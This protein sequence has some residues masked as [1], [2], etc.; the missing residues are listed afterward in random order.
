MEPFTPPP[1]TPPGAPPGGVPAPPDFGALAAEIAGLLVDPQ[2]ATPEEAVDPDAKLPGTGEPALDLSEV[3]QKE[4]ARYL[5]ELLREHDDAYRSRWDREQQIED[6]YAMIPDPKRQGPQPNAAKL[7]SELTKSQVDQA[8]ARIVAGIMGTKPLM[9]VSAND[10]NSLDSAQS[11]EIAEATEIFLQEYGFQDMRLNVKLPL[12][13]LRACKLGTAVSRDMWTTRTERVCYYDAEGNKAEETRESGFLEVVLIHNNDVLLWPPDVEE[14]QEAEVA[15]H[16]ARLSPG[17]FR[18][19]CQEIGVPAEL[20]DSIVSGSWEGSD[21]YQDSRAKR[22]DVTTSGSK[23]LAERIKLTEIWYNGFLPAMD[24]PGKFHFFLHE[25]SQNLL[26]WDYNPLHCQ[27]HPYWPLHYKR[28]DGSAWGEGVGHELVF[29]QAA[30][31]TLDN[32]EIDNLKVVANKILVAKEGTQAE[33]LV[34]EIAP[35]ARIASENPKE[36]LVAVETG[37]SLDNIYAA[38]AQ[39]MQRAVAATGLSSILQGAG[40]PTMKS[41]ADASSVALLAQEGGRKFGDVDRTMRECLDA[42]YL[43]F[44]EVIQ[45]FAPN[46]LF[47]KKVG[48][49][50]ASLVETIKYVPPR[51]RVREMFRINA[52]APSASSNRE[53]MKQNV[54]IVYNLMMVHL[55]TVE[56]L[57][58]EIYQQENP[59]HLVEMKREI[60]EFANLFF[61]KILELHEIDAVSPK[62]PRLE[63]PTPAEEIINQLLAQLQEMGQ[64]LAMLEEMM[65]VP[66]EQSDGLSQPSP[67]PGMEGAMGVGPGPF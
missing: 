42:E 32:L 13:V 24:E 9:A 41:G 27:L 55:Q 65:G 1:Q 19:K 36:D 26:Y 64:R 34:N 56:R 53:T 51:G 59:A 37:G 5:C 14:W 30:A 3:Q 60:F 11:V 23:R 4:I 66:P 20:R 47:Y 16:R 44:L 54:M 25:D 39:N 8:K 33:A 15:G 52:Q 49:D 17:Q 21:Q 63:P 57:G 38:K 46:G 50:T 31:S 45:Q 10:P 12:K 2:A 61:K 29:M 22:S 67:Q 7:C 28:V 40:D 6:A 58:M 62:M 18:A 43:F 48:E 35:G